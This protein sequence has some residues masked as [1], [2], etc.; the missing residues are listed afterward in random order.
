MKFFCRRCGKE[1]NPDMGAFEKV[2]KFWP[3]SDK[4]ANIASYLKKR[5]LCKRCMSKATGDEL[6]KLMKKL[7]VDHFYNFGE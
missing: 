3:E 6:A 5:Y 7:A 2:V 1:V 4:I